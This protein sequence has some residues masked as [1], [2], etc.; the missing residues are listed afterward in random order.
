M[1]T[2]RHLLHINAAPDYIYQA[3]STVEGISC[4]WTP[5]VSLQSNEIL[6]LHFGAD[7]FKC[8]KIIRQSDNNQVQWQCTEG[9]DEWLDTVITFELQPVE[10]DKTRVNFSHDRWSNSSDLYARCSY[11]WAMF[12]RSMK[13]YCENGMG[14]PYPHQNN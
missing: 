7:Y 12:L 11:D 9:V 1:A 14:R 10:E 3:I 2:I 8:L 4:W 6:K 5:S 13:L